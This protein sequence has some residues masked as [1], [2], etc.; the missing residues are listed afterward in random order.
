MTSDNYS[1]LQGDKLFAWKVSRLT[2]LAI[3]LLPFDEQ[4]AI[5]D[6]PGI[7]YTVVSS[8]LVEFRS[9]AYP[10]NVLVQADAEWLFDE[11]DPSGPELEYTPS[12]DEIPDDISELTDD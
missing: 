11:L 3:E 7:S 10:D 5:A 4:Q 2:E 12:A 1:A 9:A 6:N 8:Q